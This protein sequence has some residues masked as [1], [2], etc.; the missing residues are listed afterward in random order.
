[1]NPAQLISDAARV[2][3][4][5]K[6]LDDGRLVTLTGCKIYI[7]T[8]FSERG[9]AAIGVETHIVGICA[10]VV[11]GKYL[12]VPMV[13]AMWRIEPTSTL[14][15]SID[16][17]EYYEFEFAPGSTVLSTNMLVRTDTLV[18]RIYDEIISKGRVPWYINYAIFGRLFDTA[19]YHAGA[20]IGGNRKVIE[21]IVS[22][23]SRD[24]KDRS[25]FYRETVQSLD[26]VVKNPPVFVPLR[27]VQG[28]SNTVNKLAGSYFK[29]GLVSALNS[30]SDRVE[31]IEELL[32]L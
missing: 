30:P 14:K 28:A 13:N 17:E 18:Y 12:S 26:D 19:Q 4:C 8:R 27:S 20:N 21:L 32:R 7:P 23:I 22:L 15:I 5:F 11:D 31:R 24:P 1:M 9:L 25:K 16:E 2:Q 6:Q 29:E 10:I 3:A